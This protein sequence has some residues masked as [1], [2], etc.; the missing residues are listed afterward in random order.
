MS[1]I[2]PAANKNATKPQLHEPDRDKRQPYSKED[3]DYSG[4]GVVR[5]PEE[6]VGK[7]D[8][9]NPQTVIA[10]RRRAVRRP[11]SRFA[12]RPGRPACGW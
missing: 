11:T 9:P 6:K 5:P 12:R 3:E 4:A 10:I 8:Q 2:R 7:R 1:R